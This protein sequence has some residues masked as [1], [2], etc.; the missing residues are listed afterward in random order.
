MLS[1]PIMLIIKGAIP[2]ATI[3]QWTYVD[4]CTMHGDAT[5]NATSGWWTWASWEQLRDIV[6]DNSREQVGFKFTSWIG[7]VDLYNIWL[8]MRSI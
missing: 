5:A 3:G 2:S 4:W 7:V 1:L 8:N 6:V